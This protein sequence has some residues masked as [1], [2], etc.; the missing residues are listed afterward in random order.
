VFFESGHTALSVMAHHGVLLC[1]VT[2]LACVAHSLRVTLSLYSLSLS[3]VC[4]CVSV[5][6]SLTQRPHM[7]LNNGSSRPQ[8][9]VLATGGGVTVVQDGISEGR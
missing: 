2:A 7:E 1:L 4:A 9:L 6:V 8:C 3:L 5:R